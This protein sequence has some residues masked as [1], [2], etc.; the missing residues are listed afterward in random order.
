MCITVYFLTVNGVCLSAVDRA[1]PEWEGIG[2]ARWSD[3]LSNFPRP[4]ARRTHVGVLYFAIQFE[5]NFLQ[6]GQPPPLRDVVR[7]ADSVAN[8]GALATNLAFSAHY[9][10]LL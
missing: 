9:M 4:D 5:G 1:V 2:E 8:D 10:D 7:V 3:Y 6:V